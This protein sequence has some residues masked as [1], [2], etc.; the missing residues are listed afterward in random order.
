MFAVIK[1]PIIIERLDE[2]SLTKEER[3][4]MKEAL[5]DFRK[6]KKENFLSLEDF[7]KSIKS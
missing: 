1:E 5:E 4:T 6:G 2:K 7:K 3:K